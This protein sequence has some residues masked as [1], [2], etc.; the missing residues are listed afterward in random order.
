M[1][2]EDYILRVDAVPLLMA[3][4]DVGTDTST[5]PSNHYGYSSSD[6]CYDYQKGNCTRRDCRFAPCNGQEV[7]T[8]T[9]A[10]V[11]TGVGAGAADGNGNGG[12]ANRHA[13]RR[14]VA[15]AASETE[16]VAYLV[17]VKA[18]PGRLDIA[19]ALALGVPKDKTIAQL[20]NGET[21]TLKNGA[22]VRQAERKAVIF[23]GWVF[24]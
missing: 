15:A 13:K 16:L 20:K 2:Y 21:V 23:F 9:G 7:D 3:P 19:K 11:G 22:V 18:P 14:R 8:D 24:S 17:T 4:P 5:P 6:I 10:G 1:V 12:G